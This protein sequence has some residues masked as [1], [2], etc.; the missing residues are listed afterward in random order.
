[1]TVVAV[2]LLE[3]LEGGSHEHL[4]GCL[5]PDGL[6]YHLAWPRRRRLAMGKVSSSSTPP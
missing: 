3:Q 5:Q 2:V 4:V 6:L 1:M